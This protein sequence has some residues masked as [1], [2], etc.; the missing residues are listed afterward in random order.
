MILEIISFGEH[1]PFVWSSFIFTFVCFFTLYLKTQR[2]LTKQ[3]K[4]IKAKSRE[5]FV[6]KIEIVKQK[7]YIKKNLSTDLAY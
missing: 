2:D 7:K 5:E 1:G 3:E 6:A 4:L